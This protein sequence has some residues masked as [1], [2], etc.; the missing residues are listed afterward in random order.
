LNV[1][2][3]PFLSYFSPIVK[4]K[5]TPF[6]PES[7]SLQTEDEGDFKS[8][9]KEKLRPLRWDIRG[10]QVL[11]AMLLIKSPLKEFKIKPKARMGQ[12]MKRYHKEE[13]Y[14]QED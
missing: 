10:L 6:N 9:D 3:Y 13:T 1:Y 12:V 11:S 8:K 7:S 4:R 5:F 14:Q 2:G